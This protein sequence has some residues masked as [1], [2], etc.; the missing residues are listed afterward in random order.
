MLTAIKIIG[1]VAGASLTLAGLAGVAVTAVYLFD[2]DDKAR[3]FILKRGWDEQYGARPLKRAIQRY[4]EDDLADEIIKADIL[5]GDTIHITSLDPDDKNVE[6]LTFT[7]EKGDTSHQ[8]NAALSEAAPAEVT[9][10]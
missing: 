2:L 9:V 1:K 10:D 8:F 5:P 3:D 6:K 4:I 7:I